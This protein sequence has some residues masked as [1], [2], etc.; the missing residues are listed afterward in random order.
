MEDLKKEVREDLEE[1]EEA[2]ISATQ[3]LARF[4]PPT[5][6]VHSFVKLRSEV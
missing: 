2:K 5:G 4:C 3:I 6:R 1:E